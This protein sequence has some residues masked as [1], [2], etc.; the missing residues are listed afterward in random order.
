MRDA[1]NTTN[2]ETPE[3]AALA[4]NANVEGAA[5][6]LM[7]AMDD[8][9][10][11]NVKI[12]E[13]RAHKVDALPQEHADQST[14]RQRFSRWLGFG[15]RQT[16]FCF[17]TDFIDPIAGE[18]F[19]KAFDPGNWM[20]R[21]LSEGKPGSTGEKL[22]QGSFAFL[23]KKGAVAEA[24]QEA[25]REELEGNAEAKDWFKAEN[26]PEAD[27]NG[28]KIYG[29]AYDAGKNK[30]RS[31]GESLRAQVW[32]GEIIGDLSAVFVYLG[33]KTAFEK[34]LNRIIEKLKNKND[35]AYTHRAEKDMAGWAREHGISKEDPRYVKRMEE[36]KHYQAE[37]YVDSA[38][39]AAGATVTNVIAQKALG[40]E[41]PWLVVLGGKLIGSALTFSVMWGFNRALPRTAQTLDEEADRRFFSKAVHKVQKLFGM[42][43]ESTALHEARQDLD[44]KVEQMDGLP[45]V[46]LTPEERSKLSARPKGGF[47]ERS[48]VQAVEAPTQISI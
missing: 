13:G 42:K 37:S 36:F 9:A 47:R 11:K 1:M 10:T 30:K 21:K 33:V 15:L 6:P 22:L 7:V 40:N 28:R 12:R 35:R 46:N 39:I 17:M 25:R 4:I 24:Q 3:P 41:R 43:P 32:L 45:T 5:Q 48:L 20:H 23:T 8:A 31:F 27:A 14:R 19:Q 2:T 44:A 26:T 29:E 18:K 34:P 38:I 16:F